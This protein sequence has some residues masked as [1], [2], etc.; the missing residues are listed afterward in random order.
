VGAISGAA[1]GIAIMPESEKLSVCCPVCGAG[2]K[3]PAFAPHVAFCEYCGS[4]TAVRLEEGG[5]MVLTVSPPPPGAGK[6]E[7]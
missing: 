1:F 2:L 3:L 6:R 4:K 7:T 5:R